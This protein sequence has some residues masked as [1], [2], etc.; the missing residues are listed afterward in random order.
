MHKTSRVIL[1]VIVSLKHRI[2]WIP[3]SKGKYQLEA[4]G[5]RAASLHGDVKWGWVQTRTFLFTLF[6]GTPF[7][8]SQSIVVESCEH[9]FIAVV[10]SRIE[11]LQTVNKGT[12]ISWP[13]LERLFLRNTWMERYNEVPSYIPSS[14]Q[15]LFILSQVLEVTACRWWQLQWAYEVTDLFKTEESLWRKQKQRG[16]I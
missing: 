3:N 2:A 9:L 15:F 5:I 10:K 8:A 14:K 13:L 6:C 11:R 16:W 4:D 7:W 12:S 1:L